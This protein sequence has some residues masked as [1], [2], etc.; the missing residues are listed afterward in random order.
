MGNPLDLG[1]PEVADDYKLWANFGGD[2]SDNVESLVTRTTTIR[3]SPVVSTE[4][5]TNR[6]GVYSADGGAIC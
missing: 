6:G 5:S 2:L 3:K 4:K 1:T